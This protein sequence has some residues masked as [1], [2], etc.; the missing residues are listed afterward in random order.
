MIEIKSIYDDVALD[1]V[2]SATNGNLDFETFNRMSKR[3]QLRVADFLSGDVNN[4][5]SPIPYSGQK[6]KDWLSPFIT[7]FP[8]QVKNG[9]I[10][11]PDDYYGFENMV[12]IGNVS[13]DSNCDEEEITNEICNTPIELL[14]GNK[15][16]QRCTS[17]IE[18]LRPSLSKPIAKEVGNTFEFMPK[19]L[20]SIKLE[21][22]RYPVFAKIVKSPELDIYHEEV[23]DEVN[24]TNY[25]YQESMRE[26]L[27]YF[28][29]QSFGIKVREAALLQANQLQGKL[30]RD[31]K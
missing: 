24:S 15:F 20:G 11:K 30:V 18:G 23:I 14:D 4:E 8:A 17:F 27:V 26:L 25:E 10:D 29:T 6:I 21:Y 1:M 3:G 19:D 22:I 5:K 13:I 31:E 16:N 12:L 7:P 28:I 2:D 9:K